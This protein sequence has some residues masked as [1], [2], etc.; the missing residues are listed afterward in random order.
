MYHNRCPMPE[1][2]LSKIILG[3]LFF[4]PLFHQVEVDLSAENRTV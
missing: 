1:G 3:H 2:G 4:L